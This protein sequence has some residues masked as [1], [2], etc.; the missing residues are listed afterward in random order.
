MAANHSVSRTCRR[1]KKRI[2][3]SYKARLKNMCWDGVSAVQHGQKKR[4]CRQIV[5]RTYRPVCTC[6]VRGQVMD[7]CRVETSVFV[8]VSVN[9]W[10]GP[11]PAAI[12]RQRSVPSLSVRWECTE[13]NRP[14]FTQVDFLT[15]KP[16]KAKNTDREL[17]CTGVM[18]PACFPR[19]PRKLTKQS[20]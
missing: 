5:V 18:F 2:Q 12:G 19:R 8:F 9:C 20:G 14:V 7:S 17:I 4:P 6:V 11:G 13:M 15:D 1:R 16:S 3:A 10:S